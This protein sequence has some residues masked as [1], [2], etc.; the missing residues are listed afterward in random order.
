MSAAAIEIERNR[1]ARGSG[2]IENDD[3]L[4]AEQ[5]VYERRL[6]DIGAAHDGY[7]AHAFGSVFRLHD[8]GRVAA[9]VQL[10]VGVALRG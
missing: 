6:P 9:L 5:G 2:L 4:L 7:F 3:T 8:R 1:V 10:R